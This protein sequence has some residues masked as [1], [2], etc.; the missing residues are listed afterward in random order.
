M[1]PLDREPGSCVTLP[2][3]HVCD[4]GQG[5]TGRDGNTGHRKAQSRPHHLSDAF[6]AF[7]APKGTSRTH[8][9]NPSTKI[10]EARPMEPE[11]R[12]FVP[13]PN[14]SQGL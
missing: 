9:V 10:A 14:A 5:V 2:G 12:W 11:N 1:W 3:E 13:C 8:T 4:A 6:Q 7:G